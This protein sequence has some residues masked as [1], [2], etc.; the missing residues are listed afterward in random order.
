MIL[1]FAILYFGFA[2]F[3]GWCARRSILS[4]VTL[5]RST[6]ISRKTKPELFWLNVSTEI[7]GCLG[8]TAAGVVALVRSSGL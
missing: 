5:S 3:F 2:A 8:A 6:E 4:G 1:L 7:L